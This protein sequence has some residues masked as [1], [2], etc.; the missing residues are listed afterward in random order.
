M[1]RTA[2]TPGDSLAVRAAV[3]RG[4]AGAVVR[5][6]VAVLL[7]LVVGLLAVVLGAPPARAQAA[8]PDLVVAPGGSA[9][10]PAA[11]PARE[12]VEWELVGEPDAS[13]VRSADVDGATGELVVQVT[14]GYRGRLVL[15]RR[16]VDRT[17][18]T[19]R[20]PERVV[21]EVA[22][23]AP[24]AAGERLR[25][26]LSADGT[27]S[28][29]VPL[30]APPAGGAYAV[31]AGPGV[32][33]DVDPATGLLRVEPEPGVAGAGRV[34]VVPLGEDGAPVGEP[35]EVPVAFAPSLVALGGSGR[36]DAPVELALPDVVGGSADELS[37]QA[38]ARGT[39]DVRGGALVVEPGGASGLLSLA[40]VPSAGGVVGDPAPV[41][42]DVAPVVRAAEVSAAPGERVAVPLEVLGTGA[43][44]VL[45]DDAGAALELDGDALAA[46]VPGGAG[47]ALRGSVAVVDADGLRSEPVPVLVRVLAP[48]AAP[49]D[50]P[51]APSPEPV[52]GRQPSAAPRAGTGTTASGL[53]PA[54]RELVALA[55]QDQ[56]ADAE[57]VLRQA[58]GTT[59]LGTTAVDTTALGT[60][61]TGTTSTGTTPVD[62][63]VSTT[64]ATAAAT[65]ALAGTT[66]AVV[67]A[68]VGDQVAPGLVVL[69]TFS[70]AVTTDPG[71]VA[72]PVTTST[73]DPALTA[74][75]R[76]GGELALGG[77]L[78]GLVL[79]AGL[80]LLV[81]TRRRLLLA[82]G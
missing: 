12:G 80:G 49:A 73:V 48:A 18:G 46:V 53:A 19:A 17:T 68:P 47:G 52:A 56:Q 25:A 41:T 11:A 22:D 59:A 15:A 75:P 63:T 9:V 20:A 29:E 3:R 66:S 69:D 6:P 26:P 74:L 1:T 51:S 76:T 10:L 21:V 64:D 61:S 23:E 31:E 77:A 78:G 82:W 62:S 35:L 44:P 54:A 40:V 60:T 37:V 14:D 16:A 67:A 39:A 30:P 8:G 33:A 24:L 32:T 7:A 72:A 36:A 42:V 5:G 57:E 2:V 79:L 70:T 27:A 71:L 13:L 50:A 45:L 65:S 43:A 58:A 4:A 28:V 38:G 81:W 34:S 55:A